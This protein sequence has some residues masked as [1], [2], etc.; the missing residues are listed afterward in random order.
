VL[1]PGEDAFVNNMNHAAVNPRTGATHY[2]WTPVMLSTLKTIGVTPDFAVYHFYPQY[3]PSTW[4]PNSTESDAL[5]LQVA[6]NWARDAADIRQQITDYVGT[7]G[8]NIELVCTENNC[9]AGSMGRQSTS[10]VNALYLADSMSQLMKTEFNAYV[11]WDLRN[12]TDT[13]GVFD[14]TLYGWRTYGDYGL[15]NGASTRH[16]TFYAE[17]LL[18]SFV[19]SGDTILNASSDSLW[20]SAYAA[21][22]ASGALGLLVINKTPTNVMTAQIAMTNFAPNAVA[23]VRSFG[24]L[25]D[26]ATRTN[27]PAASKDIATN[28]L[29]GAAA[30]FTN[31]FPPY[32]LTLL[33]FA[34]TAPT[35]TALP[36]SAQ[37]PGEFVFQLQGQPETRY[38]IQNSANLTS[39]TRVA[40]NTLLGATTMN[41]TNDVASPSQPLFWR[42][43]WEP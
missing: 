32:S 13:S 28:S 3:T 11:W 24:L 36:V 17:K 39:W 23:T 41:V 4:Q 18:Q 27:G 42:A 31:S 16:P 33:T 12:G 6:V 2:G 20:L 8:A 9:D 38:V 29:S 5:Q 22:K 37:P 40:T 35:L 14:A 30:V 15:I 43:V 34:P 26:E 25:Q 7:D 1:V 10:I 19:R 21:R